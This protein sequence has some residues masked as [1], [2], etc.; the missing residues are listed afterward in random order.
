LNRA[1]PATLMLLLALGVLAAACDSGSG[2]ASESDSK[3]GQETGVK[4]ADFSFK[5]SAISGEAG[6]EITI[7]LPN[8]GNAAH[9]FTVSELNVDQAVEPGET[10]TVKVTPDKDGTFAFFCRFHRG[11][12]MEG[13]LTVG[14]GGAGDSNDAGGGGSGGGY[15]GY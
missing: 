5:P 8:E 6:K 12:G 7:E 3:A 14:A 4:M 13:K 15:Y 9:T 1:V 11:Q 2:G 10:A